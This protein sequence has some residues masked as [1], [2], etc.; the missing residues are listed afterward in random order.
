MTNLPVQLRN[1][2]VNPSFAC[3][4]QHVGI[5]VVVVL[6][7][8]RLASQR[9]AAL[10]AVDA[11][12]RHAKLHPRLDFSHRFVYF[13][14]QRVHV[15]A[16]PVTP[17]VKPAAIARKALVIRKLLSFDR[18]GVEVVVHVYGVHVIVHHDVAHHHPYVPAAFRQGR[19]K[20][21]LVAILYK[22]FRVSV[23]Y[24]FRSQLILQVRLHPVRVYPRMKLHAPLVAFLYHE[25]H[26]VP[27]RFGRL[28]LHAGQE[29]APWF[30]L[31]SIQ[32]VSF[33]SYLKDDGIDARFLQGIQLVY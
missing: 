7:S 19:V 20:E 23:I 8:V 9:I 3:P 22:P 6:Q 2:V 32:C 13:P 4:Q 12:G 17:V 5:Q 25:R 30:Y 16:S 31:R 27:E 26:R 28:T 33:R 18:I 29:P 24:M 10:V 21:Q 15:A 14:Y 11:E 1:V